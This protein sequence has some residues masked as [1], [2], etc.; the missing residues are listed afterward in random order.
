VRVVFLG[1]PAEVV[2]LVECLKSAPDLDLVGVVSQPPKPVGRK[3]ILEDPPVAS[4]A[5][6]Q[7]LKVL[8]P[9][10][11]RD[12]EF[13]TALKALTPDIC[14]TAAYGQ[15]LDDAFLKIPRRATIN[16]H[17]S[18]LPFFRGATPIP[19]ALLAG[20]NETAVTILFT[21]RKL[22][23]GNI[24][25]QKDFSIGEH[26]TN[27]ALTARLFKE[28]CA[29]VT[30]S[31]EILRDLDFVGHPQDESKVSHCSKISK[32]DGKI[33][34]NLS[35]EET[36]RKFRAYHPWPGS[37]TFLSEQRIVITEM[38]P[39]S[40]SMKEGAFTFDKNSKAIVAG[41]G[42]GAVE[43]HRLKPAGSKEMDA[44]SFWNGLKIKENLSFQS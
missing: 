29:M 32:E 15:I 26:E 14:V 36:L 27:G 33:L 7:G 20:F 17:P 9:A 35:A 30:E 16:V 6:E 31:I 23:A 28:S 44:S 19:T 42:K 18:K 12:P 3:Q 1:S 2:P 38:K 13:Q 8:Q 40:S 24:I 10:S 37:F 43:I 5:K 4:F 41:T 39:S 34:W 11:A 22:D 25:L 21:V